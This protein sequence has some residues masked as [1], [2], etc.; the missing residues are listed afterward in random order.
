MLIIFAGLPGTGKSKLANELARRI[1]ATFLRIDSIEQAITGSSLRIH[2][3][4]D[5]GYLVG[6]ALAEDNLRLGGTVIADSVNP[7][8]W[9]GP[10]G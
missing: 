3:V 10:L 8:H 5:A 1:G 2:P 4:E 9:H 7:I 6:Y